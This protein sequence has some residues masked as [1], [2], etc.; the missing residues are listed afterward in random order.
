MFYLEIQIYIPPITEE[1]ELT[2]TFSFTTPKLQP[3]GERM[4]AKI[5]VVQDDLD[6]LDLVTDRT[7]E[8]YRELV[9]T[10]PEDQLYGMASQLSD[11]GYGTFDECL[12]VLAAQKGDMQ[13]SQKL[14]SNLMFKKNSS[15]K[16]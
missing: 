16:Q 5:S 3:F 15:K 13:K 6:D 14:L 10:I 11:N 2:I 7:D 1:T 12:T 9:K 8:S 4:V